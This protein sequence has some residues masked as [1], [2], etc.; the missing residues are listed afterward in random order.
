MVKMPTSVK[1]VVNFVQLCVDL[2]C[3]VLH[4]SSSFNLIGK[5]SVLIVFLLAFLMFIFPIHIWLR[6]D[7]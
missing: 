4:Q 3:T 2:Q 1:I 5:L 6:H 7:L